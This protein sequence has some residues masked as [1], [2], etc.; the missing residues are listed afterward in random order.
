VVY[1]GGGAAQ[2]V[3]GAA[4]EIEATN[5]ASGL[6]AYSVTLRAGN[7]PPN[8]GGSSPE[9]DSKGVVYNMVGSTSFFVNGLQIQIN[10]VA[11]QGGVLRDGAVVD[12]DFVP[13]GKQYL[14]T[15]ISVLR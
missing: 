12:V 4:V 5:T 3:D 14:A 2:L 1:S 7:G 9:L 15:S 10:G 13:S 8:P 11:P 6:L